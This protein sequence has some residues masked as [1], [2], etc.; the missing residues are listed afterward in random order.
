MYCVRKSTVNDFTEYHG[1]TGR[2][3]RDCILIVQAAIILPLRVRFLLSLLPQTLPQVRNKG[4]NCVLR[5][6]TCSGRR[7]FVFFSQSLSLCF[8]LFV[9]LYPCVRSCQL[10]A[11]PR[12]RWRVAVAPG[13]TPC[14]MEARTGS[15]KLTDTSRPNAFT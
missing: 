3:L 9:C 15:P 8:R 13:T 5:T 2:Y 6:H 12:W 10:V 7:R 4:T 11:R 14:Q 1:I